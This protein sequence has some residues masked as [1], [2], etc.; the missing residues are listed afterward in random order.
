MPTSLRFGH[1]RDRPCRLPQRAFRRGR[2]RSSTGYTF[3]EPAIELG[4]LMEDDAPVPGGGGPDPAVHAE[5][6]RAGRGRD[7]HR[8]DE[9]PAADGRA[10]LRRRA[11]RS[12]PPTSR[13]TCPASPRPG[14]RATSCWPGPR[15]SARTGSR[16]AARP[17]SSRSAAR[18]S[19]SRCGRRS[20]RSGRCCW[21]RCSV[22]NE[23]QESSLGLVFHYADQAGLPL[24]DLKDLR[25]VLTH[26]TS[27]EGKAELKAIGGLSAATA[28]VILR[29]LITFA[30]QGAE[31][32]FGE[33]EFDTADLLRVTRGR[34]GRGLAARAAQPARPA[35]AVLHLPDVAAG[36]PVPRPARGRRR[37]QAQAGVLLRRGAPAVRRRV[38]GVPGRDR[39]DRPADPVEGRRHLLRHPDA[40]RTCRT[41][42]WPSSARGCS[43]SCGRTRR[44]TPRR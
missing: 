10:D 22:S 39:A 13:A 29:T 18:D 33:P 17:S 32:F 30:D 26:L 35:G 15:R 23:V 36:R 28:G 34:P 4:V 25:A 44:T 14:S 7:R 27:D 19:A 40:R 8:Q 20:A 24:L 16:A 41:T 31:E 43:T 12:S 21:P 9:D 38:E 1:D 42:C 37:R 5:P 3:D 6:A 2:R 11:S